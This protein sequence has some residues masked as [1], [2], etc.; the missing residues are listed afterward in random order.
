MIYS[1]NMFFK[2]IF[3]SVFESKFHHRESV[4]ENLI[5]NKLLE[6]LNRI[7]KYGMFQIRFGTLLTLSMAMNGFYVRTRR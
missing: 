1:L 7:V 3:I 5:R 6:K 4:I 2:K